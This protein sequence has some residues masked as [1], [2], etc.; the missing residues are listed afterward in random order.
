MLE[1]E[2]L[3]FDSELVDK[4]S[5][6]RISKTL[7]QFLEMKERTHGFLYEKLVRLYAS[8]TLGSKNSFL[9]V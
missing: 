8:W 9:E 1:R 3:T 5:I 2:K 4:T 6:D 7:W